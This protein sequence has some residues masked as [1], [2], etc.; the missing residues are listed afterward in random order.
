MQERKQRCRRQR[1]RRHHSGGHARVRPG[2]TQATTSG[3]VGRH[4]CAEVRQPRLT[5]SV[6]PCARRPAA[7]VARGP[8]LG[9]RADGHAVRR[10]GATGTLVVQVERG[11]EPAAQLGTATWENGQVYAHVPAPEVDERVQTLVDQRH[12]ADA[13]RAHKSQ[14]TTP[15]EATSASKPTPVVYHR[16]RYTAFHSAER[17]GENRKTAGTAGTTGWWK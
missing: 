6:S 4:R 9:Q 13:D 2:G 11:A 10:T 7:M 5:V 17:S 1:R 3:K 15:T 14:G 12:E 8:P 16:R